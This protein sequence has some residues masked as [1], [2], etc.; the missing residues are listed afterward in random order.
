MR[1]LPIITNNSESDI[2]VWRSRAELKQNSI[3]VSWF[4]DDLVRR[5]LGLVD[6]VRVEDVELVALHDL[7][8]RVVRAVK[9]TVVSLS[10]THTI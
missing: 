9:R 10:E 5:R 6:E 3:F 4:L 8:R 1:V 2:F 7:G